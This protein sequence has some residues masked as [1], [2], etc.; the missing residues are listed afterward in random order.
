M[1]ATGLSESMR[2]DKESLVRPIENVRVGFEYLSSSQTDGHFNSRFGQVCHDTAVINILAETCGAPGQMLAGDYANQAAD[3]YV[4]QMIEDQDNPMED[5]AIAKSYR[6]RLCGGPGSCGNINN[7]NGTVPLFDGVG[8]FKENLPAEGRTNPFKELP[9]CRRR[10]DR[11]LWT[12]RFFPGNRNGFI[13]QRCY[14][15]I[16]LIRFINRY[17]RSN[18]IH[19]LLLPITYIFYSISVCYMVKYIFSEV[20]Q[21]NGYFKRRRHHNKIKRFICSNFVFTRRSKGK[22]G[23]SGLF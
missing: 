4:E 19:V 5:D 23:R 16:Y 15:S 14:Y 2:F 22:V 18:V 10:N 7:E 1:L 12:Y 6:L 8:L 20:N 9:R 21:L 3:E 13:V 17:L 11:S